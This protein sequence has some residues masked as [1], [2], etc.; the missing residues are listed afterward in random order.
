MDPQNILKQIR[1]LTVDVIEAG[2]CDAQN[3]P[4]LTQSSRGISEIGISSVD[5]SDFSQKYSI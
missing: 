1:Q 4:S 3:F 5:N 2:I